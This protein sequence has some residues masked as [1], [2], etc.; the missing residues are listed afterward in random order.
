MDVGNVIN[1]AGG[2]STAIYTTGGIL[3]TIFGSGWY[4]NGRL[5]KFIS[6]STDGIMKRVEK[7]EAESVRINQHERDMN[8][9]SSM[10]QNMETKLLSGFTALT[11][12]I[13]NVLLSI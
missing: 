10:L 9:L 2:F 7:L 6:E 5:K 4:I 1:L 12:R 3:G 13:D 11:Q 8:Q